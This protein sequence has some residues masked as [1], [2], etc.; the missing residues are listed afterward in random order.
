LLSDKGNEVRRLYGVPSTLGLIPGR[1][2]YIIDKQ[3][4]VR[5]IFSSQFQPEKHIVE[6]LGVLKKLENPEL[7]P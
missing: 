7:T 2:T 4:V 6:A 5:H 1:V 3:G